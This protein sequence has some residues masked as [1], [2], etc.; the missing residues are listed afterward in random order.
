MLSL[1]DNETLSVMTIQ[2]R[3]TVNTRLETPMPT[4]GIS[5]GGDARDSIARRMLRSRGLYD[6]VGN[7]RRL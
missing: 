3:L 7:T 2:R 1:I 4:E 6:S 5:H